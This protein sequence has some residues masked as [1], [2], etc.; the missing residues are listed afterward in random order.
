MRSSRSWK[1]KAGVGTSLTG[2]TTETTLA[3][4]PVPANGLGPNGI[5]RLTVNFSH[6]NNANSK[7]LRARFS[8]PAGTVYLSAAAAS[9][10]RTHTIVYIYNLNSTN[11]Q[12]GGANAGN[13]SG[14]G[15]STTPQITSTVDTTV[16]TSIVITGE[17]GDSADT[18][19]L[20]S[21]V[22]EY[23]YQA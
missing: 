12:S 19:T 7:T 16:D 2:T 9:Q 10:I 5:I 22:F 4:I 3:T 8:G 21:Y 6:T 1:V 17:L 11:S 18:I 13:T 20:V 15:Q 14:L 23:S